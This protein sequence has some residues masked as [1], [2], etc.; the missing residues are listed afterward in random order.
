MARGLLGQEV[1]QVV[2]HVLARGVSLRGALRQGF[3]AD[4]LQF[5]RDAVIVLAWRAGLETHHL[6]H[7]LRLRIRTERLASDQQFVE[8]DAQA[9]NVA[10]AI[11]PVPFAACLFRTHVGGRP[12][13]TWSLAHILSRNAR[14]KSPTN[15][16]PLLVEQDIAGLDVPM[17]K[18]LLVG[19]VQ[20]LGHRRHQFDGFVQRQA[21]IA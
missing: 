15:G 16:L 21:G 2:G 3:Q 9:E 10:A 4:A 13:V 18:P 1:P 19:V 12:G 20:R 6:V 17:H 8:D 5:F 11:D 14:P 7:K